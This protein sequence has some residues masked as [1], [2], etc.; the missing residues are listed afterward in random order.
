LIGLAWV[1]ADPPGAGS[2]EPAHYIKAL[3]VGGGDL[4]G[5]PPR[6]RGPTPE[7]LKRLLRSSPEQ[8]KRFKAQVQQQPS[9]GALWQQRTSREFTVPAGLSFDAFGCGYIT[10]DDWGCLD[11]GRAFPRAIVRRS[12]VGTYQPYLYAL[13]GVVMRAT[14]DPQTAMRLGRL[15]NAVLSLGLLL[16]AAFVLWD[17]SVGALSLSGLIVAVTPLVVLFASSLNPSGP[18]LTSAICFS[19]CLLRLTRSSSVASRIWA[20]TAAS[21]AILALARSLG[22]IFVVLLVATVAVVR[23]RRPVKAALQGDPQAATASAAAIAIACAGGAFWERQYQPHVPWGPHAVIHGL[24]PSIDNLPAL[25]KQTVAVFGGNDIFMPLGFYVVW[26]LMLAALL[27][28]ALYVTRARE[29]RSVPAL[30]L[31]VLVA[32]L[33]LSAVYR[34]IGYELS[35]RYIL[36]YAA[37]LPLWAGELIAEHG[38]RLPARVG[39]GMLP[40]LACGAAGVHAVAWLTNGRRVSVGADGSWMFPPDAGWVPPLGWWPW[41]A[42]VVAATCAYIAAGVTAG[43]VA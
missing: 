21:G 5:Q 24:R 8:L 34:Q 38:D 20:I 6:A 25:L 15:V 11:D 22:P 18:E 27:G 16:T 37:I 26:W 3:G 40:T 29:R 4:V 9:A 13:P 17:R 33:V 41:I 36:P 12:Y 1:V 35:A 2:D 31:V 42:V 43:R 14:N 10:H 7:Q 28:A 23:G 32:T 19:A 30:A 39:R